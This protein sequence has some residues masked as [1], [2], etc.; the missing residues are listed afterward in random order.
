MKV[1]IAP[2]SYKGSLSSKEVAGYMKEGVL[3]VCPEADIYII[4]MADG[5]EGTV[6]AIVHSCSGE[7]RELRVVG[8]MWE[9]VNA[10][11]GLI[12]H[13]ETAVIEVAASSGLTLVPDTLRNPLLATSYGTGQLI[14]DA[15]ELGVRKLIIGLGG[16][17]INDGGVGMAQALGIKFLN[18]EEEEIGFGGGELRNIRTI[19]TTGLMPEV[20]R[21]EMI[22]ASDVSNPLC[23]PH[24]ASHI[25][26]PQK[27]A[28][29]EMV[30]LLDKGL[31]H[32][33][34]IIDSQLGI[35]IAELQGAGAAGGLGAG[36]MGFLNAKIRKGTDV[37]IQL[38]GF[39]EI[40]QQVDFVITGEGRTD[41]QTAFGKA[42]AGI[43]MHAKK[44]NIPVIC[45]SGGITSEV[46]ELYEA[47]IDFIVGAAQAPMNLEESISKSPALIKHAV[48]TIVKALTYN[49][50]D[51]G[52]KGTGSVC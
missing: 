3:A 24:G 27:G 29:P 2:D 1:L 6:E 7:Y 11:Y 16:S 39:E 50:R 35:Q 26:G 43:A 4:P 10:K 30:L 15:L 47:G 25:F 49:L 51:S 21:C 5:G 45:V 40:I 33:A 38:S 12:D 34:S 41:R 42:P 19:D 28:T 18:E 46:D 17:A 9:P 31:N 44:Y 14:R 52:T 36:L 23:G 8:P 48:S 20:A 37:I 13:G 22:I 32:L